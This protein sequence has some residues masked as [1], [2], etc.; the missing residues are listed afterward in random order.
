[1]KKI[2]M[3]MLALCC[4]CAAL[5][6]TSMVVTKTDGT[7]L[8][9]RIADIQD[10]TFPDEDLLQVSISYGSYWLKP[11]QWVQ[12]EAVCTTEEGETMDADIEW[13]SSDESVATVNSYGIVTAKGDGTCRIL[14]KTDNGQSSIGINVTSETMLDIQVK[15]LGNTA[16]SYTVIPANQNLRYYHGIRIQSG[17]YSVDGMD[18]HGSEEQNI[19]HFVMDWWDFCGGMYGMSW[20]DFMNSYGLNTGSESWVEEGMKPGEEYCIYAFAMNE[21]GTLASPVEVRKVTTSVPEESDI[22]FEVSIDEMTLDEVIFTVVPSNNDKYFVNVQ[23]ASY[24]DWF[25]ENDC[26]ETEMVQSLVSSISPVVYPE[27][28]CQGTVTR[29]TSDFLSSIRKNTDYYV[30][31]FGYDDGLTS[32]VSLTKFHTLKE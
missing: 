24:V 11:G 13:L 4:I 29:S 9:I 3:T 5:A 10:I 18:Q 17:E 2:L 21:D 7:Q 23:R 31:V 12:L 19:F 28:Y 30:I 27:A 16:C 6:Q 26:V 15:S 1:M 22:T 32:A 14:A 8:S 25:I 20:L